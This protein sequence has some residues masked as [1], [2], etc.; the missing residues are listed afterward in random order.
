M[1]ESA[2]GIF[3][4]HHSGEETSFGTALHFKEPSLQPHRIFWWCSSMLNRT[5]LC[6]SQTI[7]NACAVTGGVCSLLQEHRQVFL[8][9]KEQALSCDLLSRFCYAPLLTA[10]N[11]PLRIRLYQIQNRIKQTRRCY[12]K[13][14]LTGSMLLHRG[15]FLYS[16]HI[17]I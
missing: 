4:K 15:V 5:G 13:N 10:A 12:M 16:N 17:Y 11:Q 2:S 1:P 9:L 7:L 14:L 8:L 6:G 3:K